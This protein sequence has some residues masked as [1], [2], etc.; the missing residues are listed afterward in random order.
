MAGHWC[1]INNAEVLCS[2]ENLCGLKHMLMCL[3]N[4]SPMPMQ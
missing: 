1:H 4:C 3:T 2:M